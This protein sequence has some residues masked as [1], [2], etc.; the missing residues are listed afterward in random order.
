M[1]CCPIYFP[2]IDHQIAGDIGTG[3]REIGFLFGAYKKLRNEFTGM[4]TGKGLTWGGSFIRTGYGLIYFVE[5]VCRC[6]FVSLYPP[7]YYYFSFSDDCHGLPRVQP[8]SPPRL[9]PSPVLETLRT[10]LPSRSLSWVQPSSLFPT[11]RVPSSQRRDIQRSS[12]R[13]L[14]N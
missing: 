12:S 10:S 9:L 5:H 11:P 2:R 6:S 14:P 4:L 7:D 1:R 13:K 8:T 3:G